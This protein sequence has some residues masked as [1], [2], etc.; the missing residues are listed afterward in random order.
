MSQSR[1]RARS[2]AAV[3]DAA[4]GSAS[5]EW[6]AGSAWLMVVMF[7]TALTGVIVVKV[8]ETVRSP[9]VLVPT[10]GADPIQAP[11][12][13]VVTQVRVTEGQRVS[14]G[15][16]L[17]VL[18]SDEIRTWRTELTAATSDLQTKG[19]QHRQGRGLVR[20]SVEYQ[21]ERDRPGPRASSSSVSRRW[22]TSATCCRAPTALADANLVSQATLISEQLEFDQARKGADAGST[23]PRDD[24]ARASA[25]RD[26]AR[27]AG[28]RRRTLNSR[29]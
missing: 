14:A 26:R 21:E 5:D 11:R 27:R 17:F 1:D 29:S 10:D 18:R 2:G 20:R 3:R 23:A 4:A 24:R 28:A 25:D 9:F 22:C 12:Q 16:E 15:A 7:V 6:S 8:P 13:A 19:R